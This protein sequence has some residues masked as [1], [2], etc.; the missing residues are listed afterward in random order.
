MCQIKVR[1]VMGGELGYVE[2]IVYTYAEHWLPGGN[3]CVGCLGYKGDSLKNAFS[4]TL[5]VLFVADSVG[6]TNITG[7]DSVF[8][9]FDAATF[10]S[11]AGEY[12]IHEESGNLYTV[13][14]NK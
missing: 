7:N 14:D 5:S 10:Q 8:V 9:Q 1:Y 3:Y 12:C 4:E 11:G 6:T 2:S 13:R